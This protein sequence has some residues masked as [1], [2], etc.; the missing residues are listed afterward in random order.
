MDAEDVRCQRILATVDAVP[1]GKVASYGQIAE[2]AL[3]P[4][5]AR[6]VGRVLR[7]LPARSRLPW[8]RIVRSN[9]AIAGRGDGAAMTEQ[10]RR[11]ERE[12]VVFDPRGRIDLARFGWRP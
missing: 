11:L 7:E 8:H 4:G 5:R 1:R 3:L 10:R 9:G 6:L 12:G 2:H